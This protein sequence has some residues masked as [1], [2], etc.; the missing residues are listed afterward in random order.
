MADEP[1]ELEV[2]LPGGVKI[3]LAKDVAEKVIAG[4]QASKAEVATLNQKLGAIEAEKRA[5]EEARDAE[6]RA[7]EHAEA[8]RTGDVE[9]A[10]ELAAKGANEKLTKLAT[11]FRDQALE[12]R[13]RAVDG[14]VPE[15]VGD[16]LTQLKGS[17]TFNVDTDTLEI[18][19]AAGKP[20]TGDDGKAIGADAYIVK[21]LET[22]PHFRVASQA[23][24][25]GAGSKGGAPATGAKMTG[26]DFE[27][28]SP[29]EGAK[30][31]KDGGTII[32]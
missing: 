15:A 32:K 22:R 13:I 28:L 30:F 18:L 11:K 9:K 27:K 10:R 16:I 20:V 31:L 23:P 29:I 24:G 19:D 4:R 25:S 12:S 3:K 8:V 26:P 5:A 21:F 7:K 14:V 2:D 6:K 1:T 17:C